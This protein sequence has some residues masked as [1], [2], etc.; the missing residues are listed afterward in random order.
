MVVLVCYG[1]HNKIHRL[2]DLN[3]INLF[4]HSSGG[5]KFK[6]KVSAD[7]VSSE[8]SLSGLCVLMC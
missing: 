8:A 4:S 7:L 3:N 6:F 1:C 5:W 2:G